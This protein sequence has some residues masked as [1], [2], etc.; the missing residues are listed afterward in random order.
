MNSHT[1]YIIY[2]PELWPEC[3]QASLTLS[4]KIGDNLINRWI[5]LHQVDRLVL[6]PFKFLVIKCPELF[7]P[8][9]KERQ[10]L[11]QYDKYS[12]LSLHTLVNFNY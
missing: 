2:S 3:I 10:F 7:L 11:P 6:S 1:S 5:F 8:L 4:I 9:Q 12:V